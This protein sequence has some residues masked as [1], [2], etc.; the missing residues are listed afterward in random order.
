M[1]ALRL[2]S[3]DEPTPPVTLCAGGASPF[4]LVA[5][6]AGRRIPAALGDL[7]VSES[8]LRRHIAWDV[9]IEPV[10]RMMAEALD[11]HAIMQPY[12]R[13]VIDCNRPFAAES[14]IATITEN[15]AM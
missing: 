4:L 9:G 10:T 6:H 13:L 1:T 14:S 15:T 2:L 5:D 8:E 11:A 3:P 12:S 7:G